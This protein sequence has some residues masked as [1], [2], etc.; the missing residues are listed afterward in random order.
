MCAKLT[1]LEKEI[2]D[3]ISEHEELIRCTKLIGGASGIYAGT[4]EAIIKAVKKHKEEVL[5]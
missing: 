4:I 3:I 1:K 5:C 2:L